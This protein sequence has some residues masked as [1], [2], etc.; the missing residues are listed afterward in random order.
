MSCRIP[1][2]R[3]NVLLSAQQH[4]YGEFTLQEI[5]GNT[6][7]AYSMVVQSMSVVLFAVAVV[8]S[9]AAAQALPD[10]GTA[11][12]RQEIDGVDL[13]DLLARA[14]TSARRY[15]EMIQDLT[16][17]ET[18]T[19]LTYDDEGRVTE[20]RVF[21]SQL[22]VHRFSH[23]PGE[24]EYRHVLSVDGREAGD[25]EMRLQALA[26]KLAN[27]SSASEER[28]LIERESRIFGLVSKSLGASL[29]GSSLQNS[30][31]DRESLD[32]AIAGRE[33]ID[34]MDF[35]LVDYRLIRPIRFSRRGFISGLISPFIDFPDLD[36]IH[37]RG[38]LWLEASSGEL[39]RD[40]GGYFAEGRPGFSEDPQLVQFEYQYAPS[41]YGIFTPE[42]FEFTPR[43][44]IRPLL[45]GD[46]SPIER[47]IQQFSPFEPFDAD[48]QFSL[49]EPV[50]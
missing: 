17:E 18:T 5:G 27:A 13:D 8:C 36:R 50:Q 24:L 29:T 3:E 4:D 47:R 25:R 15:A 43:Y 10:A 7:K 16:T 22:M 34:G 6:L 20:R 41:S 31:G 23:G 35:I 38:R 37:M 45:Q 46:F 44:R 19:I 48:V 11:I 42:R 28:E 2:R 30:F 21:V 12:E 1:H 26:R 32:A 40:E 33:T 14:A 9:A 49:E 39:W